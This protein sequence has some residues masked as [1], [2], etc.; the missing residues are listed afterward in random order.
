MRNINR[1]ADQFA[2][3]ANFAGFK[4]KELVR[5]STPNEAQASRNF[6]KLFVAQKLHQRSLCKFAAYS[7][8]RVHT[9]DIGNIYPLIPICSSMPN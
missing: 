1:F 9:L 7:R 3:F 4:L 6:Q 2:T 5:A 8:S